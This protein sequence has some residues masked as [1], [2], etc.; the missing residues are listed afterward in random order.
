M[1]R[2]E[3]DRENRFDKALNQFDAIDGL[4]ILLTKQGASELKQA[5]ADWSSIQTD[6]ERAA[7]N[8]E[9]LD[10]LR[11]RTRQAKE[12]VAAV[13]R[14]AMVT[15]RDLFL[16]TDPTWE[17]LT[18]DWNRLAPRLA[19]DVGKRPVRIGVL[20]AAAERMQEQ[21]DEV[22]E[23]T[24][25]RLS[26]EAAQLE[27]GIE[28]YANH[29]NV[30][31]AE[32]SEAAGVLD[33]L[34][35]AM[36]ALERL[37]Q[38]RWAAEL[39]LMAQSVSTFDADKLRAVVQSRDT[40]WGDVVAAA[41]VDV[42]EFEE[43]PQ[44]ARLLNPFFTSELSQAVER[45][46][47]QNQSVATAARRQ[48]AELRSRIGRLN[49]Q[50]VVSAEAI[51]DGVSE[52]R[53]D[54]EAVLNAEAND[55][56]ARLRM[57][58]ARDLMHNS[59]A[60]GERIA[61]IEAREPLYEPLS[62]EARSEIL[63]AL[64]RHERRDGDTDDDDPQTE[65]SQQKWGERIAHSEE[66]I[67]AAKDVTELLVAL[68][69]VPVED[70]N[71]VLRGL[72]AASAS[73]TIAT[74]LM[75]GNVFDV[76]S[77]SAQLISIITGREPPPSIEQ[78][79]HEQVMEALTALGEGQQA[80]FAQLGVILDKIEGLN[81]Q[82]DELQR[83]VVAT[84]RLVVDDQLQGLRLAQDFVE[85]RRFYAEPSGEAT[86]ASSAMV[87]K[88]YEQWTAHF[89]QNRHAYREGRRFLDDQVRETPRELLRLATEMTGDSADLRG[90]PPGWSKRLQQDEERIAALKAFAKWIDPRLR[91]IVLGS[92]AYPAT[93][94]AALER[95]LELISAQDERAV[96]I[97]RS[98]WLDAGLKE[99]LWKRFNPLLLTEISEVL[100]AIQP[101]RLIDQ[102]E[103]FSG[104]MPSFEELTAPGFDPS[105]P[106]GASLQGRNAQLTR[107]LR[108]AERLLMQATAQDSLI[109]GDVLLPVL[110][111]LAMSDSLR[112]DN[113]QVQHAAERVLVSDPTLRH[114]ALRFLVYLNLHHDD[115]ERERIVA[116]ALSLLN[117]EAHEGIRPVWIAKTQD[118]FDLRD[119]YR[120]LV[121]QPLPVTGGW[122]LLGRSPEASK[123]FLWKKTCA[124]CES[125]E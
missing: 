57:E 80:I 20:V 58:I 59:E 87:P 96:G 65:T 51:S 21:Q 98:A 92:M 108:D 18:A 85:A 107:P 79:R 39:I 48:A 90:L 31:Q 76:I 14:N 113:V 74:G 1:R 63:V 70:A 53:K 123:E 45:N 62:D 101:Y 24:L 36:R 52:A 77:G 67:K 68:D 30:Q 11:E 115:D 99:S 5:H 23:D 75:S 106:F 82:L 35:L 64:E 55:S 60:I 49:Q 17:Q 44:A 54:V 6:Y 81:T 8:D 91:Q 112:C 29:T 42:A 61:A 66:A 27:A 103:D 119:R 116:Q 25:V 69:V 71:K 100:V 105:Q 16:A 93:N 111:L 26:R 124:T 95:K 114:N 9:P 121:R 120:Q 46:S 22:T 83:I 118:L 86:P 10:E 13:Q 97:W 125:K 94:M 32:S 109:Q 104:R 2:A 3:L 78:L 4:D 7:S 28:S 43:P 38:R 88:D 102:G 50:A 37:D 34:E 110:A 15:W 122:P 33:A 117:S 41:S 89:R 73:L 12:R 19:N 47:T 84:H 72:D 56:T 40:T